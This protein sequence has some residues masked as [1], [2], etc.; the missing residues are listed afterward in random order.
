M[1]EI[2]K[3][4]SDKL[5]FCQLKLNLVSLQLADLEHGPEVTFVL[6]KETLHK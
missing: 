3:R 2:L 1:K 6:F 4:K 5:K